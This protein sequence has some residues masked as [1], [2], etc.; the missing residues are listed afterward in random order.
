MTKLHTELILDSYGAEI[1][2]ILL[3]SSETIED[4]ALTFHNQ[5]ARDPFEVPDSVMQALAKQKPKRLRLKTV[6]IQPSLQHCFSNGNLE[7]LNT[8]NCRNLMRLTP[9]LQGK[10]LEELAV[11]DRIYQD[12]EKCDICNWVQIYGH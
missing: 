6:A 2:R 4:L 8:S 1:A 10:N 5:K 11:Q 12:G 9:W 7:S 3:R